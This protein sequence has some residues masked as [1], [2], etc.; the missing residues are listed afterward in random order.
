ML[1]KVFGCLVITFHR[2]G[3]TTC[4][5]DRIL[6]LSL[7]YLPIPTRTRNEGIR[8][9]FFIPK[10]VKKF[11]KHKFL[12]TV[13]TVETYRPQNLNIY[14]KFGVEFD[15]LVEKHVFLRLDQVFKEHHNLYSIA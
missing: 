3:V 2:G 8:P 9:R 1:V 4:N 12:D 10:V 14:I 7:P 15:G 11:L 13:P 6:P 5:F